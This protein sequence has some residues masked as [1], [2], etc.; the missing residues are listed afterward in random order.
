MCLSS[1]NLAHC[2]ETEIFVS[3]K[4]NDAHAGTKAQPFKS[5]EKARDAAR[6][7]KRDRKVVVWLRG[8]VYEREKAFELTAEDS[9]SDKRPVVYR[10]CPGEEAR[11][12]GGKV[13]T[14]WKPV[15]DKA[16]LARLTP[17]ARGK[18]VQADLRALGVTDYG[19]V[20]GGGLELFFQNKPMTLARWPNE[21]FIK[22]TGLV[23]PGTVNVRGTKGSKTGKFMYP[24]DRP[25]R[26]AGENDAW[27]HGYWFWDWSDQ[28]H[29]IRS[30]DTKKRIIS[31]EPPYHGYGYRVGQWFY[32]LNIL[33]ELD[34]PGEW[35][36]DREA[37]ILY[38]WPPNRIGNGD[39]TVSVIPDLGCV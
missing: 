25:K 7:L 29:A 30:I 20:K 9:G 35:Y 2:Q 13:V 17:E 23:E 21:G 31:V 39:A 37:G 27:V 8:G 14:E 22:I 6:K 33:A 28:R 36:V 16:V 12:V 24:G 38:F 18:V 15:S 26:W 32:A 10:A 3:P 19:P 5:L 34:Q 1:A 11:I 4:G